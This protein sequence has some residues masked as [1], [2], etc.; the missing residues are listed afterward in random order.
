MAAAA[1]EDEFGY[2]SADDAEL[3]SLNQQAIRSPANPKKRGN[4]DLA[5]PESKRQRSMDVALTHK[6]DND[7]DE[8]GL[9]SSNEAE[10]MG[11][12]QKT[13]TDPEVSGNIRQI[14]SSEPANSLASSVAQSVLRE[15]FGLEAFRLKQAAAI[16]RLLEG[17]S[18]TVIFPTGGGKSLCYQ[19]PALAFEA[20]D[21]AQGIRQGPG[22][23]GI[24][25]VVSP[26]IALM[27]DQV[28]ALK[29]KGISAACMDSTKSR[30][31]YMDTVRSMQDGTLKILYCA[32]ER[33]NNEGFVSSMTRV[34]G[35]VRLL[36]VDEAHCVSEWGHAF[37]PDYLKVS[38][39]AKEI[40]AERVVCLTATATPRV[41][42]DVCKAFDIDPDAGTFR[43]TTYRSNLHLHAESFETKKESYPA[44]L[45]FLRAHPG[46]TIIYVTLQKHAEQVAND[47]R[48]SG[49]KAR[50]FHAGMSTPEKTACQDSF[51]ASKDLII[52]A[53]IAFGMGIDKSNIRTIVH[54]DIPRSVEGYSQEIG[55]AG[56]DGLESNCALFLCSED[57]HLR[58]SFARGDLPS[59]KSVSDLL[60]NILSAPK[61]ASSGG[62]VIETNHYQQSKEFDVKQ[63]VLKSVYAQLELDFGLLR[64]VTPKYTSYEYKV[65]SPVRV[66]SDKSGIGTAVRRHARKAITNTHVDVDAVTLSAHI[67]RNDVITKLNEWHDRG[68]IDL[69]A[70]GV[71]NVYRVA[72]PFPLTPEAKQ[73]VVDDLYSGMEA[74]ERMELDRMKQVNDLVT[75]SACVSRSLAAHF[76]DSLPGQS[77]D[78]GHCSW[79]EKGEPVTL[80]TKDPGHF[81]DETFQK[82]LEACPDRDDPRLLARIAF[83]IGSP[84][85]TALKLNNHAVFG[86]MEDQ[87]FAVLLRAF[88]EACQ[89]SHGPTSSQR[90][91]QTSQSKTKTK[92]TPQSK[93]R[94]GH[95]RGYG[96]QR[97]SSGTGSRYGPLGPRPLETMFKNQ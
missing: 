87:P 26:L 20:M 28:D 86:S 38:R 54:Y 47:I 90:K 93:P 35:G 77:K 30:D 81:D 82:V 75:S 18:C 58:E 56:R 61:T 3:L 91:F 57:M 46:P 62:I 66:E 64:A 67:S 85:S 23:G 95:S 27:K 22:E 52:V 40:Q 78:C 6:D 9:N 4:E 89:D 19:V 97:P 14:Q 41:A 29:R 10:L 94:G 80:I 68:L 50:H 48:K 15:R 49:F 31:E 63:T 51:M 24:T 16:T 8:F 1:S 32:P 42:T 36:A 33:L 2:S 55:R 60:H 5:Q 13:I 84:R 69:K 11:L 37:R 72:K 12:S 17:G 73:S 25:I 7:D 43:T 70:S 34:R 39:F 45:S 21:K 88:E 59:K 83:G 96:N 53:T 79:C 92:K 65:L 76:D 74:R 71:V 44:L